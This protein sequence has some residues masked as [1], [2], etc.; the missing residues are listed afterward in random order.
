MGQS[1]QAQLSTPQTQTKTGLHK[2]L[3]S[4]FSL[5]FLPHPEYPTSFL[6]AIFYSGGVPIWIPTTTPVDSSASL[7]FLTTG[8]LHLVN[9]SGRTVWDSNTTSRGVSSTSIDDSGNLVLSN[10]TSTVWSS[11]QNPTD[12]IV[13]SQNPTTS[14]IL[15]SGS[16]SFRLLSSGN[17]THLWNDTI[18]YHNQVMIMPKGVIVGFSINEGC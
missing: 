11:F 15:R 6:A 8:S 10:S 4:I 13:P 14:M 3:N 17:L 1:H 9:G 12:T 5:G 18:A 7:Q 16:Y 2:S